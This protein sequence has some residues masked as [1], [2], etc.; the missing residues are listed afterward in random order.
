MAGLHRLFFA[1]WPDDALR[2]AITEFARHALSG[3]ARGRATRPERLHM[4]LQFLGE[5]SAASDVVGRA[6]AAAESSD[7]PAAFDLALDRMGGFGG[8]RVAWLGTS[9]LPTELVELH[10]RL[11]GALQAQ[12][13]QPAHV[14]AFVPHVT[15]ARDLP[16]APERA[17]PALH[18]QVREFV[19]VDSTAGEYRI[20]GRWPLA[21]RAVSR[22]C[23]SPAGR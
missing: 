23:R 18:W 19:L 9:A 22:G 4:T 15:L 2:S 5:F 17:V 3:I 7:A 1:L 16:R 10:R 8:G 21:S 13:L 11:A 20:L 14:D 6:T 12:G